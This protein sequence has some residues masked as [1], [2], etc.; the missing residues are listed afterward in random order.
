MF[1]SNRKIHKLPSSNKPCNQGLYL[2]VLR[3]E[4]L[5]HQKSKIEKEFCGTFYFF[6]PESEMMLNMGKVLICSNKVDCLFK[7]QPN[8][9]INKSFAFNAYLDIVNSIYGEGY[10]VDDIGIHNFPEDIVDKKEF[11]RQVESVLPLVTKISNNVNDIDSLFVNG[12]LY[13]N[14]YEEIKVDDGELI[15]KYWGNKFASSWDYLDQILCNE[16]RKQGYDTIILQRETGE[17]RI[18]TEILD[19]RSRVDS[20]SKLCSL[21]VDFPNSQKYP[22]LWFKDFSFINYK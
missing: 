18:N 19:V 21:K 4:D 2:P 3:Y 17:N 13:N 20:Y 16:A 22:T 11:K 5:Y 1:K 12:K 15:E 10:F 6:E 9:P 7:L 14:F 8:I